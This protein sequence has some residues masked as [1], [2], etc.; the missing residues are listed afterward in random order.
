VHDDIVE[1]QVDNI[2]VIIASVNAARTLKYARRRAGMTQRELAEAAGV[3]QPGIARVERGMV[4]PRLD[5]LLRLLAPTGVTLELSP[6]LGGGVDRSLIRAP[7]A[8]TPEERVV[9][10]GHAANN[11]AT[12][13]R[14]VK[15]ATED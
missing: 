12:F 14:E 11:L 15:R 10:A 5:T 1:V 9:S 13:L 2:S 3:P 6:H 8:R 4:V 7:L